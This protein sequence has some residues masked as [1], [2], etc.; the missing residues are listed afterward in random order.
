MT[1]QDSLNA[2]LE[3]LRAGDLMRAQVLLSEAAR[4][5]PSNVQARMALG[6]ALGELGRLDEA[7]AALQE[8]AALAPGLAAAHYNLGNVLE[9]AG[10]LEEARQAYRFTLQVDPTHQRAGAGLRRL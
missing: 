7:I 4:A 3:A 6:A 2:G 10:R 1:M 8:A 9:K 5:D